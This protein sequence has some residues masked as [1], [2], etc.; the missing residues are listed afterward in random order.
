MLRRRAGS[1]RTHIQSDLVSLGSRT[2]VIDVNALLELSKSTAAKA[3]RQF[4]DEAD[5]DNRNYVHSLD[6][7][8]EVKA[9]A[10]T[11]LERDI[12]GALRPAGLSILTEESGDIPGRLNSEYKFIVDPLD[13]TFNYVKGLGRSAVSIA[14]WKAD[15]PVFGVIFTL[16]DGRLVWGGRGLGAFCDGHPIAVS[17]TTEMARA[18]VCTGFPV[19]FDLS[20]SEAVG[21]FMR[22]VGS[23]AKVRMLGSAAI[24]LVHVATG[25]ADVYSEDNIMPWDVAAG[26][27][28][29]EGAGGRIR[30]RPGTAPQARDAFASN[31]F[32]FE[33]VEGAD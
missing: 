13:G 23:Y 31:P 11:V 20:S 2:K 17:A 28:I 26:L 32:L 16:P 5:R 25:A 3:G 6:Q 29:V 27:A 18:S 33:P 21:E 30:L 7:P 12:L 22:M 15:E 9:V 10:D 4:L 19:R 8:R 14:L 24:S 1:S